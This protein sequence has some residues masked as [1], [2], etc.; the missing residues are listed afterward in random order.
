M[1]HQLRIYNNGT[2]LEVPHLSHKDGL[3]QSLQ[4]QEFIG[5]LGKCARR[6]CRSIY[7]TK[8]QRLLTE[9]NI[10]QL[11]ENISADSPTTYA[12]WLKYYNLAIHQSLRSLGKFLARLPFSKSIKAY[13]SR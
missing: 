9:E 4:S 5:S 11:G 10:Q 2:D 12:S 13:L 8:E 1:T 6:L 7:M 3:P